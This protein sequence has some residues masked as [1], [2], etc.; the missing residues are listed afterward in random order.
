MTTIKKNEDLSSNTRR[1]D[2]DKDYRLGI[3]ESHHYSK[4]QTVMDRESGK[5]INYYYSARLAYVS[6][7]SNN[8]PLVLETI[9]HRLM[10]NIYHYPNSNKV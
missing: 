2:T 6:F 7:D 4:P 10:C 9:K 5:F 1:L 3:V 8:L